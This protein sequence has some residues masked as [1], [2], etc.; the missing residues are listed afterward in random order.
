MPEYVTVGILV[1]SSEIELREPQAGAT[2]IGK[3]EWWI[4]N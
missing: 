1:D 3:F 2:K 4:E